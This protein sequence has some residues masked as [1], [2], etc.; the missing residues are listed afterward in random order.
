[1][2]VKIK[3]SVDEKTGLILGEGV[4]AASGPRAPSEAD[5]WPA[6]KGEPGLGWDPYLYG[7][8]LL[9]ELGLTRVHSRNLLLRA[10]MPGR[11]GSAIEGV[12]EHTRAAICHRIVAIAPDIKEEELYH[13]TLRPHGLKVGDEVIH[14]SASADPM[15][16]TRPSCPYVFV[17]LD[18][19]A[20]S[21]DPR[22]LAAVL[23]NSQGMDLDALRAHVAEY[24]RGNAVH[25]ED[26][27]AITATGE[28]LEGGY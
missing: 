16:P 7:I 19:L 20:C 23:A 12:F 1:M 11:R 2:T 13:P 5:P 21:W 3:G 15:D 17:N 8:D 14:L 28:R 25:L 18:D 10:V 6:G 27:S 22:I 4:R 24:L 9:A 26:G